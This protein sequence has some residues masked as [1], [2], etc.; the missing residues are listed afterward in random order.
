MLYINPLESAYSRGIDVADRGDR[1]KLAYTE[2]EHTFLY[3]LLDE[4][5]KSMPKGGLFGGGV[6][7]DFHREMMNDSL[8][9]AMAQSGQLGLA[10]LMQAQQR[11]LLGGDSR[12]LQGGVEHAL[13][14]NISRWAP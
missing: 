12:P 3:M 6:E 11:T 1:Q 14:T 4:M 7:S 9:S 2:L 8:S 13:V 10:K 5:T